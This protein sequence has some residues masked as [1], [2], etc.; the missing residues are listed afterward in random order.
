MLKTSRGL[1]YC[2]SA[3]RRLPLQAGNPPGLQSSHCDKLGSFLDVQAG[4]PAP[5]HARLRQ[6]GE[7]TNAERSMATSPCHSCATSGKYTMQQA[8][9]SSAHAPSFAHTLAHTDLDEHPSLR[10]H[11]KIGLCAGELADCM[12]AANQPVPPA[13]LGVARKDPSFRKAGRSGTGGGGR[14]R[15]RK[16]VVRT[17]T[18]GI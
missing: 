13:L 1:P 16:P 14:G 8:H 10:H 11:R 2:L 3:P 17:L 4:W 7:S 15:G 6:S 12:A 18:S 9:K 5:A